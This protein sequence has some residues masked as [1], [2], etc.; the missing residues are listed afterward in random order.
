[1]KPTAP[2]ELLGTRFVFGLLDEPGFVDAASPSGSVPPF[3]DLRVVESLGLLHTLTLERAI[4]ERKSKIAGAIE[5]PHVVLT[6][7]LLACSEWPTQIPGFLGL[8]RPSKTRPLS[9]WL[10]SLS[11]AKAGIR[12]S[13]LAAFDDAQTSAI[14]ERGPLISL[15]EAARLLKTPERRLRHAE[16][17]F[18]ALGQRAGSRGFL[19]PS[20]VQKLAAADERLLT[21]AEGAQLL[22]VSQQSFIAMADAGLL[23]NVKGKASGRGTM[24]ALSEVKRLLD[25]VQSRVTV[26]PAEPGVRLIRIG[27]SSSPAL[28]GR[29]T[30]RVVQ[31]LLDQELLCAGIDPDANGLQRYL[32][33]S[34]EVTSFLRTKGLSQ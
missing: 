15:E 23:M 6:G 22:G 8:K 30:V 34:R 12:E 21:S 18:R 10:E 17:L 33:D 29:K 26:A 7:A 19:S 3:A 31:A 32:L 4:Y 11:D 28:N 13:I 24:F 20:L 1:M 27:A 16:S 5:P 25:D 2:A 9:R 14:Q